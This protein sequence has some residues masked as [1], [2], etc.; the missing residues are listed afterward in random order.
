MNIFHKLLCLV[1][2]F[3]KMG[4]KNT[5]TKEKIP[6]F[7]FLKKW[8]IDPI[9]DEKNTKTNM[10]SLIDNGYLRDLIIHVTGDIN[11]LCQQLG[12]K[13]HVPN[14]YNKNN[15]KTRTDILRQ[16]LS[17]RQMYSKIM[18]MLNNEFSNWDSSNRQNLIDI[19]YFL[20]SIPDVD[21]INMP[22]E[23]SLTPLL[24]AASHQVPQDIIDT[25]IKLGAKT[26]V[27]DSCGRNYRQ[28]LGIC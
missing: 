8:D 24:M 6:D 16:I 7:R 13:P 5:N 21:V 19:L 1:F 4:N 3:Y 18:I 27:V 15:F 9:L 26:D 2:R 10:L 22:C 20:K 23:S 25:L 14:V 17:E 11:H 12:G 28:L